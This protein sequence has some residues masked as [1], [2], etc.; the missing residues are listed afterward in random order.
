MGYREALKRGEHYKESELKDVCV[1]IETLHDVY[2][3]AFI[4]F[5]TREFLG[6]R[7]TRP[8]F[9]EGLVILNKEYIVSIAIVYQGDF[10]IASQEELTQ[11]DPS[12]G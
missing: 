10:V 8:D 4:E 1:S 11:D 5:E 9:T 7:V 6:I 3:L 2:N 12:Y